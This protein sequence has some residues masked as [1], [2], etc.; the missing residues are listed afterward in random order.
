MARSCDK[1]GE[2]EQTKSTKA[3]LLNIALFGIS[4]IAKLRG[5]DTSKEIK[6]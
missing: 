1:L 6:S 4:R 2:T 3:D 5:P